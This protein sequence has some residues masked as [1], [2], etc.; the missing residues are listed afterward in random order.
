MKLSAS[1]RRFRL[2]SQEDQQ[3]RH[4]N[5]QQTWTSGVQK[6]G[7]TGDSATV[8]RRPS[9]YN[10]DG[11]ESSERQVMINIQQIPARFLRAR[12]V[13]ETKRSFARD[14][15]LRKG[16]ALSH[17]CIQPDLR[18]SSPTRATPTF[19]MSPKDLAAKVTPLIGLAS[20]TDRDGGKDKPLNRTARR[21]KTQLPDIPL[22][23]KRQE[24]HHQ[25]R[26]VASLLDQP[27]RAV[28]S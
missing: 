15:Q 18:L 8:K 26:G 7:K 16:P 28:P 9:T 13:Q 14:P 6:P 20:F 24:L 22:L 12:K 5:Y 25:K 2:R 3:I 1:S 21:R 10:C 19:T 11:P 17:V 27:V 4:L 23:R